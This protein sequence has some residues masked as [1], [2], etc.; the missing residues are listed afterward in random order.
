MA[1]LAAFDRRLRALTRVL[2]T[3]GLLALFGNAVA[4]VADVVLRAGFS[5][6]I[7]R[8]SDVSSVIFIVAAACCVPAATASRRHV[9]IRAFD[10]RLSAPVREAVEAVAAL[11]TTI[12]FVLIAWQV[13]GYVAEVAASGQTL[14]QIAVPV[15]PIWAFV[16]ACLALTAACQ[17]VVCVDHLLAVGVAHAPSTHRD[18]GE[19]AGTT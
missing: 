13:G 1:R 15:A 2:A 19:E 3:F 14:S 9:T 18:P 7:D 11:L 8:L 17:A 5:A 4:V 10:S 6:P 12:V 16:T